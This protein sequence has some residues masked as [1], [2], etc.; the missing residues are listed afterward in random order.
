MNERL[1]ASYRQLGESVPMYG[2][3]DRALRSARRRRVA[4]Q[5]GIPALA[6]V[7]AAGAIVLGVTQPWSSTPQSLPPAEHPTA[8]I[9]DWAPPTAQIGEPAKAGTLMYFSCAGYGCGM[10]LVALDGSEFDLAEARPDLAELLAE[11][12]TSGVSLSY[13][14]QWLGIPEDAAYTLYPLAVDP[15]R[16]GPPAEIRVPAGPPGSHWE[17]VGWGWTSAGLTLAQWLDDRV[18]A[19]ALVSTLTNGVRV[20]DQPAGTNLLPVAHGGDGVLVADPIDTTVPFAQR[21]RVTQAT[22]RDLHVAAYDG[23]ERPGHLTG[24][25]SGPDNAECMQPTETLAGPDGVP[26]DLE[27]PPSRAI[28]TMEESVGALLVFT[29]QEE[30]LVP[31]A[32]LRGRACSG[33]EWMQLGRLDLPLSSA[34]EIWTFLGVLTDSEVAMARTTAEGAIEVIE[35]GISGQRTLQQDLPSDA[36]VLVPGS[37]VPSG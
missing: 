27:P 9:T 12:G 29:P 30:T 34:G 3:V 15:G 18:L 23:G 5:V 14:A 7:V 32:L 16:P 37:T 25:F 1:R 26:V 20:V 6:A 2:N 28:R 33:Q 21:T 11:H 19:F 10:R 13:D 4:Q 24:P 36:Q 17:V 31:S 35:V 8:E 22:V